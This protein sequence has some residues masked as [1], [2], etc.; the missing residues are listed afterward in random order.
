MSR[1]PEYLTSEQAGDGVSVI[2]RPH[3]VGREVF[4]Q[5]N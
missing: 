4:A 3:S 5:G 2:K 1:H